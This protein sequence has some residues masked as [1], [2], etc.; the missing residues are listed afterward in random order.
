MPL[1]EDLQAGTVAGAPPWF[2]RNGQGGN[3]WLP[4]AAPQPGQ[5]IPYEILPFAEMPHVI[6]PPAGWV[7]NANNDPAATTLDNNPLNQLREGGGIYYLSPGYN[8]GFR[9]GRITQL[10]R[11]AVAGDGKVSFADMQAFQANVALLDAEYFVPWILQACAAR[12]RLARTRRWPRSPRQASSRPSAAS[13]SGTS[14]RRPAFPRG[15]TPQTST[16]CSTTAPLL[17]RSPQAS[18]RPSTRCGAGSSS[19]R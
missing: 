3:E 1:R 8:A 4:G 14:R 7:V 15:T 11:D 16:V 6:N 17:R 10:V 9:A 19:A 2:I 5:A 13:S 18:P 12:R